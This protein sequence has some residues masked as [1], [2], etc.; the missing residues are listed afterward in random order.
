M[1]NCKRADCKAPKTANNPHIA[2][3]RDAKNRDATLRKLA[4]DDKNA[5]KCGYEDSGAT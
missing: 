5:S 1:G 4:H 2:V 3:R